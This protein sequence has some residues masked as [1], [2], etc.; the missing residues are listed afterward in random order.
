MESGEFQ[1]AW[2]HLPFT[3]QGPQHTGR[4]RQAQFALKHLSSVQL[5]S[6][7]AI[8]TPVWGY[9]APSSKESGM[10][11][12]FFIALHRSHSSAFCLGPDRLWSSQKY[13]LLYHLIWQT[14]GHRAQESML[15][16]MVCGVANA[17]EMTGET[18]GSFCWLFSTLPDI[19]SEAEVLHH[20]ASEMP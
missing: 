4:E 18:Q 11:W 19:R 10:D 6:P 7:Q 12:Y 1:M 15:T 5:W 17:A 8:D 14:L 20:L 9:F 3:A 13:V 2:G 16:K